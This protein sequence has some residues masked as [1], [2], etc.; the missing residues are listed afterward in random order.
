[1]PV[2]SKC[3]PYTGSEIPDTLPAFPGG[4]TGLP[5]PIPQPG[6]NVKPPPDSTFVPGNT[7]PTRSTPVKPPRPG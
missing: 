1:M 6:I 7:Y 4:G 2:R 3:G 5:Q